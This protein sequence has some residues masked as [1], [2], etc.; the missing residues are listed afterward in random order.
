MAVAS[1]LNL[2]PTN[3]PQGLGDLAVDHSTPTKARLAWAKRAYLFDG[4]WCFDRRVD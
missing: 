4:A 3:S 2:V 1:G